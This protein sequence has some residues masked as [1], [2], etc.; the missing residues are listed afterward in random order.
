MGD[1][2]DSGSLPC[3]ER[4]TVYLLYI[5]LDTGASWKRV[6]LSNSEYELSLRSLLPETE[7]ETVSPTPQ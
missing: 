7:R 5:T 4:S 1:S 2:L 6:P 3:T